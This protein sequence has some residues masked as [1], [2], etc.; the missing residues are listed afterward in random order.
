MAV[1][2]VAIIMIFEDIHILDP[3]LAVLITLYILAN[4]LK[5]LK[6]TVPVFLQAI[7]AEADIS[8]IN[9]QLANL[10]HVASVHHLHIW[11]LDDEHSVLTVHLVSNKSLDSREYTELKMQF[12]EIMQAHGIYHSTLE[13]EWPEESCRVEDNATGR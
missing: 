12:R 8:E 13:I 3:I 11:S 2:V 7:P 9:N 1:L 6:K 10:E 4:V 5:Q